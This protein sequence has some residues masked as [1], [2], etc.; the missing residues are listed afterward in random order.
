MTVLV[1]GICGGAASGPAFPYST[2]S[3]RLES[4]AVSLADLRAHVAARV[5]FDLNGLEASAMGVFRIDEDIPMHDQRLLHAEYDPRQVFRVTELPNST[6]PVSMWIPNLHDETALHILVSLPPAQTAVA[7]PS[8]AAPG[9]SLASTQPVAPPRRAVR[10]DVALVTGAAAAAASQ[11]ASSASPSQ[12]A[13][14]ASP[15]DYYAS[16]TN[17]PHYSTVATSSHYPSAYAP[18]AT[19]AMVKRA[20]MADTS[21]QPTASVS[22]AQSAAKGRLATPV[23]PKSTG[24]QFAAF[25]R[26]RKGRIWAGVIGTAVL[27]AIIIGVVVGLKSSKAVGGSQPTPVSSVISP[28]TSTPPFTTPLA[29]SAA[30][31]PTPVPPASTTSRPLAAPTPLPGAWLTLTQSQFMG[32]PL[33]EPAG[34]ITLSAPDLMGCG[35]LCR[36]TAGCIAGQMVG[37]SCYLMKSFDGTA[38]ANLAARITYPNI[39]GVADWPAAVGSDSDGNDFDATGTCPPA[40]SGAQCAALCAVIPA[41]RGVNYNS[42]ADGRFCCFKTAIVAPLTPNRNVTIWTKP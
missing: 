30:A 39:S 37:N 2:F 7:P 42:A 20:S 28:A 5:G 17:P 32:T 11:Y 4:G 3:V 36:A 22:H 29:S 25:M 10:P 13:S 6:Q 24:G 33:P 9:S 14:S 21:F 41:C 18:L 16:S 27:V 26:T 19:A 34:T 12:Y 31:S 1:H 15:S 38:V 35:M 23:P 40:A 8:W